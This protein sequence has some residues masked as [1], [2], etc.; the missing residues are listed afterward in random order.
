MKKTFYLLIIS[1]FIFSTGCSS[2][3]VGPISA[4]NIRSVEIETVKATT[5]PISL[6]YIGILQSKDLKKYSFKSSAK[7]QSIHVSKGQFVKKGE[8]LLTLDA[9]DLDNSAKVAKHQMESAKAL[10]DKSLKGATK[11]QVNQAQIGV[12]QAQDNYNFVL[13]SYEK[14][15]TLYDEGIVSKQQLDEVKLQL[16]NAKNALALAQEV[17][18]EVHQ[19]ASEEDKKAAL[20]QYEQAKVAYEA[21]LNLIED[22]T[23]VSDCNG[24]IV[25][26]L[27]KKGELAPAGYPVIVIGTD[28]PI[29]SVGLSQEDVKKVELNTKANIIT[30][31]T[32]FAAYVTNI[33]R[34]IDMGTLTYPVE[35]SFDHP[36]AEDKFLLGSIVNVEFFIGEKNGIWIPIVNILNDVEDYVYVVE[37]DHVVRRTIDILN[38]YED[39]VLVEGLSPAEKLIVKG[40]KNVKEGYKVTV[41]SQEVKE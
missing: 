11:E 21:Q 25:D 40:M 22:A 18:N 12:Q 4:E 14:S 36:L 9:S 8:I 39:K 13:E 30:E 33:N 28:E 6:H 17:E 7:I 29:V 34:T 10:Y 37:N 20:S 23:L 38:V 27:Y 26:I 32:T 41:S 19:G 16:D 24:Y 2:D 1:I 3:Q 15:K 35:L 5:L 31:D